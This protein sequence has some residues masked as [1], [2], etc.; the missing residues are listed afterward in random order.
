MINVVKR[1]WKE[2]QRLMLISVDRDM[3]WLDYSS[4][5]FT[6]LSNSYLTKAGCGDGIYFVQHL[7][8]YAKLDYTYLKFAK[9][10][11]DEQIRFINENRDFL[12]KIK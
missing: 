10:M 12:L 1:N 11:S 6:G 4:K 5:Y 9:K 8:E 3:T 2:I 7:A